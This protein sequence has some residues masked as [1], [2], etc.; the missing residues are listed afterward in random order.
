MSP[1]YL[2]E[3]EKV[4]LVKSPEYGT[5]DSAGIDFFL[6]EKEDGDAYHVEL[7]GHLLV[8]SGICVRVP[9]GHVLVSLNKSSVATKTG[10]I[11]GAQVID[12]DYRGEIHLHLINTGHHKLKIQAGSKIAQFL[13]L[14]VVTA[15]LLEV[16]EGIY[17]E[18]TG[19]GHGAFGSTDKP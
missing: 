19:R 16:S 11:C 18:K 6:P 2:L 13:L 5:T 7:H 14:P 10:L 12:S 8:P 3:Y 1:T 17:T 9:K 4:R 15:G